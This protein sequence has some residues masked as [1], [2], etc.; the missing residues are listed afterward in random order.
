MFNIF[1]KSFPYDTGAPFCWYIC[2]AAKAHVQAT[3]AEQFPA[4]S[5]ITEESALQ[6]QTGSLLCTLPSLQI[7]FLK[8][9]LP[10]LTVTRVSKIE[11]LRKYAV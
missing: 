11:R 9:L 10:P 4:N 8:K 6:V 5:D 7:T 1:R 3:P 2:H